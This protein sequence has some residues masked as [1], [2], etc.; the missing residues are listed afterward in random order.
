MYEEFLRQVTKSNNAAEE[1]ISEFEDKP[2]G[3]IQ[4]E[5]QREKKE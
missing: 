4:T 1:R 2:I 3:I 5:T